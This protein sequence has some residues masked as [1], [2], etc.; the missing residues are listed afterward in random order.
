MANVASACKRRG[1]I[2]NLPDLMLMAA[3]LDGALKGKQSGSGTT[4]FSRYREAEL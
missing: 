2:W 4:T 3:I 1:Y